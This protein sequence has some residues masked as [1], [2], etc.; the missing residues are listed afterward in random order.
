MGNTWV[1]FLANLIDG[2]AAE[3]GLF[4]AGVVALAGL[5]LLWPL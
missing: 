3:I 2:Y 4:L 5:I 1:I